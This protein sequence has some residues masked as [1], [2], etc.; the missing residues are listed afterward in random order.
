MTGSGVSWLWTFS[1]TKLG[2]EVVVLVT[3]CRCCQVLLTLNEL[4]TSD[5]LVLTSAD[6]EVLKST[7]GGFSL[8]LEAR[9]PFVSES[10]TTVARGRRLL[11]D[12]LTG[13]DGEED[14]SSTVDVTPCSLSG[15]WTSC[16][17]AESSAG[18]GTCT[19]PSGTGNAK[20]WVLLLELSL[21]LSVA[22]GTTYD[23]S[24]LQ[25]LASGRRLALRLPT[26][27]QSLG[28]GCAK[29]MGAGLANS[30]GFRC[31]RI[32]ACSNIA[33]WKP[34]C[35]C[36]RMSKLRFRDWAT[37]LVVV[38]GRA[39]LV[40]AVCLTK[41]GLSADRRSLLP[42]CTSLALC[43]AVALRSLPVFLTANS[44]PTPQ[45]MAAVRWYSTSHETHL[46]ATELHLP[47]DITVLLA[48]WHRWMCLPQPS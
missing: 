28:I 22:A 25:T 14:S 19:W 44:S 36:D 26:V 32:V 35:C 17:G 27:V 10:L 7:G 18:S 47:H 45:H 41:R 40:Y 48:T 38:D 12:C 23:F 37:F 33:C 16:S 21:S 6:G 4:L 8:S 46:R 43:S 15:S 13:T 9:M 24:S 34:Y 5:S 11:R 2:R 1:K 39:L 30:K 3:L 29:V 42:L 31:I 20:V